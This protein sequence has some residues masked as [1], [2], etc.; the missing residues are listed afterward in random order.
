[1]RR[2]HGV[3]CRARVVGV[4]NKHIAAAGRGRDRRSRPARPLDRRRIRH[5]VA[6][7]VRVKDQREAARIAGA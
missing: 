6:C 1:M 7:A 4:E 2:R 3:P 5:R